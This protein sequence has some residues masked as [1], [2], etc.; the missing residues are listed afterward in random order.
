MRAAEA[1]DVSAIRALLHGDAVNAAAS[2]ANFS[3]KRLVLPVVCAAILRSLVPSVLSLDAFNEQYWVAITPF[4]MSGVHARWTPSLPAVS[5]F[6]E[7]NVRTYVTFG[8]RPG[9]YF[10]SL[11]A[12]HLSAV[13]GARV[14]YRLPYWHAAMKVKG[15]GGPELRG[16]GRKHA[17]GRGGRR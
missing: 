11:D 2:A 7:L 14:F 16:I 1:Q 12:S 5:A 13:W 6:P 4:R 9:V 15:R 3:K 17:G 10:F 8:G